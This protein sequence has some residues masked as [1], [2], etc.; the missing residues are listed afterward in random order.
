M[1]LLAV[2]DEKNYSDTTA[3][4]ERYAV[5]G[6]I[7]RSVEIQQDS[8][9]SEPQDFY[10]AMQRG[11]N[12]EY[13]IPGGGQEPG[14]TCLEALAREIHEETGFRIKPERTRE[15]GEILE[16]RRDIFDP[17]IKYICHSLFYYCEIEEEQDALQLTDSEI[18][19]GYE[20]KWVRP[21]EIC[22]CN[23]A[24]ELKPWMMRDTAFVKML[25][26][27]TVVLPEWR[28]IEK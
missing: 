12:G 2:F 14:E 9:Q 7:R 28:E 22:R 8:M 24:M 20:L 5:R 6:I 4:L 23:L 18:E 19:Q 1:E 27:R 21:G 16:L 26:D 10:I 13:K 15:L 11:K 17:T 3:V 25:S